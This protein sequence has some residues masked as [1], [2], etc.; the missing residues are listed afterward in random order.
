MQEPEMHSQRW[1]WKYLVQWY[2][3]VKKQNLKLYP[4][5]GAV[6]YKTLMLWNNSTQFDV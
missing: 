3:H 2:Y 5:F 6:T 4:A 1:I